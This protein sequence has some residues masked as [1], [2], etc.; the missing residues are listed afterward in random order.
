MGRHCCVVGGHLVLLVLRRPTATAARGAERV[1]ELVV[2]GWSFR[3]IGAHLVHFFQL[4]GAFSDEDVKNL[5][6]GQSNGAVITKSLVS[7]L[8]NLALA[9]GAQLERG[10]VEL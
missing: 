3:A 6:G 9:G 4:G 8:C 2:P 5:E 1:R 7:G 10:V